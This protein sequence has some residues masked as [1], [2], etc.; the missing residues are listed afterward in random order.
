MY[1]TY[2]KK[3][4]TGREYIE[5]DAELD[6]EA[7]EICWPNFKTFHA[8]FKNHPSLGPGAVEDSFDS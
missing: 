5:E 3:G 8:R 4:E 6:I 2:H 1:V 7:A